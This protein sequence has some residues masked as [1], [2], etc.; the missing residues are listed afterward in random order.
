MR[1]GPRLSETSAVHDQRRPDGREGSDDVN[2]NSNESGRAAGLNAQGQEVILE[3]EDEDTVSQREVLLAAGLDRYAA[4]L[5]VIAKDMEELQE[6]AR[7]R[8][9]LTVAGG[10]VV[11]MDGRKG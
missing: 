4:Q 7:A 11:R 6:L 9:G 10:N 1:P 3:D 8:P 2:I 5:A